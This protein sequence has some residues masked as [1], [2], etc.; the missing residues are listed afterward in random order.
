MKTIIALFLTVAAG[1]AFAAND[2]Q[3]GRTG[4]PSDV[5]KTISTSDTSNACG[6]VQAEMVYEDSKGVRRV[7]TYLV[8]GGGC[9]T[10]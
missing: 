2:A 5:A 3:T 10:G 7:A 6:V 1:S 9:S 4:F 8:E